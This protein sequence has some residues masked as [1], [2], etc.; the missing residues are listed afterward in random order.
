MIVDLAERFP[1][2]EGSFIGVPATFIRLAGC[3]LHCWFCDSKN[4]WCTNAAEASDLQSGVPDEEADWEVFISEVYK[5]AGREDELEEIPGVVEISANPI[6]EVLAV[7]P[8]VP[9]TPSKDNRWIF[10]IPKKLLLLF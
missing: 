5:E 2:C 6:S 8:V 7:Y 10:S 1:P 4:T 9:G 3:N